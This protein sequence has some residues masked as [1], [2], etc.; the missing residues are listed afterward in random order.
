MFSVPSYDPVLPASIFLTLSDYALQK[1]ER[2][3]DHA[4]VVEGG[5]NGIRYLQPH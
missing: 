1:I 2:R 4:E 3:L 5:T